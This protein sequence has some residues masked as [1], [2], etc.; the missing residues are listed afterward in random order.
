VFPHLKE[1]APRKGFVEDRQYDAL[2]AGAGGLLAQCVQ[3]KERDDQVFTRSGNE[4]V[5]DFRGTWSRL[6]ASAGLPGLLFHDLRRSAVRNM[7][8][9]G[10]PE[11]VAMKISGHKTRSVFDRYDVTSGADL[12]QA[13]ARIEAGRVKQ[14]PEGTETPSAT[15]TATAAASASDLVAPVVQ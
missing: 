3:G 7:V 12:E 4:P 11:T 6:T 13:A 1:N 2:T 9:R 15:T 5:L 8:R 14:I 10:V